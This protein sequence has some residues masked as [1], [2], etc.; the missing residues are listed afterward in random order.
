MALS[1]WYNHDRIACY[2][3]IQGIKRKEPCC[4][5]GGSASSFSDFFFVYHGGNIP[6]A[7]LRKVAREFCLPQDK[8]V[9]E[10]DLHNC[11]LIDDE[12]QG[13]WWM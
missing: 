6:T 3:R 2:D 9:F 10:Q 13:L 12:W 7:G 1:R 8:T 4:H 11:D 5:G